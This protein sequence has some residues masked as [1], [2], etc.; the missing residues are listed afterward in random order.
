MKESVS[1]RIDKTTDKR[2]TKYCDSN[3]VKKS[4]FFSKAINE[5]LDALV[6]VGEQD[7]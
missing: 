5:K 2:L 6:G 1:V 3:G 7:G 4:W